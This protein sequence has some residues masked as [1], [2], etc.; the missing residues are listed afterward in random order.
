MN[1]I[2]DIGWLLLSD[3][4]ENA[5]LPFAELGR[6]VGLSLPAVAERVRRMEDSGIILGYRAELDFDKIGLPILVFIQLQTEAKHYPRLERLVASMPEVLECHHVTGVH[7]FMIKA[8]VNSKGHLAAAIAKL[9]PFGPTTTS[10]ILATPVRHQ[11]VEKP[12]DE[13]SQ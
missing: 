11:V 2:D 7:S 5:R 8:A 13:A 3:L 9:S 10:L 12:R 4:Q 1:L 6:R